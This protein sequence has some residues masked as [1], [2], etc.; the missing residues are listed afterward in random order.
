MDENEKG[1]D[2]EELSD[3]ELFDGLDDDIPDAGAEQEEPEKDANDETDAADN[4]GDE[5]DQPESDEESNPDEEEDSSDDGNT[6]ETEEEETDEASDQ[7][8]T[9]K[10]LDEVREV[11]RDEVV[12]LAQKGMDYDRI[13]GERD[14]LKRNAARFEEYESFLKRIAGDQ[15]IEDLID[16]TLAKLDVA[17]AE[18]RG[19]DLDEIEQFKKIR[20]ERVKREAK[21]PPPADDEQKTD[22][23]TEKE[24]LGKSIQR[25]LKEYPDI[26]AADIPN[27]VWQDYHN[28][29]AD[30]LECYELNQNKKLRAELKTLK[31]NQKNKER[32]TGS[33]KSAGKKS[34]DRWF[35]GWPDD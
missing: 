31:Q 21:N 27:E 33:K 5:A 17:D 26:K 34:V 13:R 32:S 29:R 8:F 35:E 11:G 6:E 20:I 19:E 1:F 16:S 25:L 4:D 3:D 2:I 10:H 15:S 22:D 9:L 7:K 14:N 30:L 18:K 28:G 12:E 23:D 24:K